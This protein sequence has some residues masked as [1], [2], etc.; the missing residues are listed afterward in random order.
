MNAYVDYVLEFLPGILKTCTHPWSSLAE[1]TIDP[2]TLLE[3]ITGKFEDGNLVMDTNA[4]STIETSRVPWKELFSRVL[5]EDPRLSQSLGMEFDDGALLRYTRQQMAKCLYG[6]EKHENRLFANSWFLNVVPGKGVLCIDKYKKLKLGTT[7]VVVQFSKLEDE[8]GDMKTHFHLTVRKKTNMVENTITFHV[9]PDV[10]MIVEDLF[11]PEISVD[12]LGPRQFLII[13]M[14]VNARV[15]NVETGLESF[16]SSLQSQNFSVGQGWKTL[17][18]RGAVK[19][20]VG[21]NLSQMRGSMQQ[22]AA[23]SPHGLRKWHL[24]KMIL[25]I[26]VHSGLKVPKAISKFLLVK[27][28]VY[29]RAQN[30]DLITMA[31]KIKP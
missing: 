9:V 23:L 5:N 20:H 22:L 25:P 30:M 3:C 4:V 26:T 18:H 17:E 8:F 15:M 10:K 31:N 14:L 19:L 24:P 21:K 28:N 12:N 27:K 6:N 13:F 29:T 1:R 11:N 16:F 2:V 7:D